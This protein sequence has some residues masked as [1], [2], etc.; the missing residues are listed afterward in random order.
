VLRARQGDS[1][2][3]ERLAARQMTDLYRIATAIVG[4][5]DA[6]DVTQEA[7]V[8]AWRELPRLREAERFVPW[9]RRILVNRCRNQL[10]TRGR[11]PA[12]NLL[13]AAPSGRSEL[14]DAD[15][16]LDV[17]D[18]LGVL[19]VAQRAVVVLHYLVGLP[20]R[21]VAETLGVPE[22]TAKSRLNAALRTLRAE[23]AEVPA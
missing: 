11:H 9:L 7:L 1:T 18:A 19:P 8:A 6:R 16:R 17:A 4:A 21:D 14:A 3:F 5:P 10:R 12:V 15:R 2:A 23:L 13:E 22:G 20:L